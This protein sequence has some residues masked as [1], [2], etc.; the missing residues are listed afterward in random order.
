MIL[1]SW[2]FALAA[3]FMPQGVPAQA[4]APASPR[5]SAASPALDF[6]YFKARVEPIFL[7]RREGHARCY[8]CHRGGSGSAT[9]YLQP[10]APGVASWDEAQS[11]KNFEAVKRLVK[12]G[13][14]AA[15]RLLTH[16][17]AEEA[18]GDEFHGGGRH[19]T[20]RNDPEWQTIAAWVNGAT[21][22]K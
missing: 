1:A 7:Y 20:S 10:L 16:P 4:A 5:G 18:G 13:D 12:P 8:V 21:L 17:L 6:E 15:S 19:W 3:F 2:L 22:R 14:P 11:L 9:A